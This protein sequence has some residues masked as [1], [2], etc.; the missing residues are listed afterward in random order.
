MPRR[1]LLTMLALVGVTLIA[2]RAELRSSESAEIK[3]QLFTL[4]EGSARRV[5]DGRARLWL[6]AVDTEHGA[7]GTGVVPAAR[8]EIDC[9]GRTYTVWATARVGEEFCGCR[10]RLVEAIDTTPPS[11]TIEVTSRPDYRPPVQA[12]SQGTVRERSGP[13]R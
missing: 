2:L 12:A 6:D 8:V 5:A 7:P 9:L 4:T 1:W 3:P 13:R 10:V 11:A